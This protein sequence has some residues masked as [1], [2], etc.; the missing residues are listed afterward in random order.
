[1]QG[2]HSLHQRDHA[3]VAGDIGEVGLNEFVLSD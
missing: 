2:E 1:M 3:I